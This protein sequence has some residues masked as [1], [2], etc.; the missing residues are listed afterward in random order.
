MRLNSLP[1]KWIST[2]DGVDR[3]YDFKHTA[4][5]LILNVADATDGELFIV[6]NQRILQKSVAFD[7]TVASSGTTTKNRITFEEVEPICC[8]TYSELWVRRNMPKVT[9]S[10]MPREKKG[11]LGEWTDE[12]EE[13][14]SVI[15]FGAHGRG[16]R[17]GVED[18]VSGNKLE[19]CNPR[20]GDSTV[21]FRFANGSFESWHKFSVI[22][23]GRACHTVTL[24]DQLVRWRK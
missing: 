12:D 24:K 19:V 21:S 11:F 18:K 14:S 17:I 5:G 15:R 8:I 1:G 23:K 20:W 22:G 13:V 9:R 2:L 7:L 4:G 16:V 10:F 3:V 6:T